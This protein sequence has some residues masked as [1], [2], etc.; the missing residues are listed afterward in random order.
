MSA[1]DL[2]TANGMTMANIA[3]ANRLKRMGGSIILQYCDHLVVNHGETMNN[4]FK[5]PEEV[6]DL[7]MQ[8]KL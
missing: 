1:S 2:E 4:F 7:L 3:G 8:G 5:E 6:F